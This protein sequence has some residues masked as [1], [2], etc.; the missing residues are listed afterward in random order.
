MKT[1][2]LAKSFK[3]LTLVIA[4]AFST[5]TA[6]AEDATNT[7]DTTSVDTAPMSE[8]YSTNWMAPAAAEFAALDKTGNGLLL[9]YEA[10]K[11]KA[12]NK[13]TF[14]QADTDHDGYID[15]NEYI[16]FK[17]GKRPDAV[18]PQNNLDTQG[19]STLT[20]QEPVSTVAAEPEATSNRTAG[21]I[22]DD[23]VIT[24][25]AKAKILGTKELKSLQISVETRDGEVLLSGVVDNAAAKIRAE[26]VVS[27]IAGV[28]SVRNGLEIRG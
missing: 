26:Q 13:K 10:S 16:Y 20:N 28:K 1:N 5:T 12:F 9:P 3:P 25:K 14:A 19:Q 7:M 17:T 21:E 2:N 22:V 24:A 15:Q 11:G 18:Q 6:F 4:L 8:T 23:S 27:Q